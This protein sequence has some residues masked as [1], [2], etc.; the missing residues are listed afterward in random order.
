MLNT[1]SS[2]LSCASAIYVEKLNVFPDYYVKLNR[3]RGFHT[4][5]YYKPLALADIVVDSQQ[6][7][8]ILISPYLFLQ[9]TSHN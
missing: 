8:N 3:L 6:Y 2:I 7:C 4:L 9:H 5:T 1:Q